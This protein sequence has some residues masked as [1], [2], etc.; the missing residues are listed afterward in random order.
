[1]P[2][3]LNTNASPVDR[4]IDVPPYGFSP[5]LKLRLAN[6]VVTSI[7]LTIKQTPSASS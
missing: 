3:N 2:C 6:A 1:M 4:H 5:H 7:G